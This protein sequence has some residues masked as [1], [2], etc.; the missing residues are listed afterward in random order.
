MNF[1]RLTV[2]EQ[3]KVDEVTGACWCRGLRDCQRLYRNLKCFVETQESE[4]AAVEL[5]RWSLWFPLCMP[6]SSLPGIT[7]AVGMI[8]TPYLVRPLVQRSS[9]VLLMKTQQYLVVYHA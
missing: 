2:T 3:L 9:H 5:N 1:V 4:R 6:G 7:L 8:L